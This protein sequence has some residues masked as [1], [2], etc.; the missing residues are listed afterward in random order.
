[1]FSHRPARLTW[2]RLRDCPG[3]RYPGPP[4]R[5]GSV[6]RSPLAHRQGT[7]SP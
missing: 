2:A 5:L 1:L 3:P 7:P 6:R 4:P